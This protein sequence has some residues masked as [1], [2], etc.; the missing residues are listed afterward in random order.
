M[1]IDATITTENKFYRN[2][3]EQLLLDSYDLE[4]FPQLTGNNPHEIGLAQYNRHVWFVNQL[5]AL[6]TVAVNLISNKTY[7]T[8]LLEFVFLDRYPNRGYYSE[9][10]LKLAPKSKYTLEHVGQPSKLATNEKLALWLLVRKWAEGT[11]FLYS[12]TKANEWMQN[13]PEV[14][15]HTTTPNTVPLSQP[16]YKNPNIDP[17]GLVAL[18]FTCISDGWETRYEAE[19]AFTKLLTQ[20]TVGTLGWDFT[21]LYDTN[22]RDA[23]T[24]LQIIEALNELNK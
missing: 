9:D 8:Q 5:A 23:Y 13:R 3:E 22:F 15:T 17:N 21:K 6:Q 10:L 14:L 12:R 20:P 2:K 19:G 4:P 18:F 11:T 24:E 1:S 16:Q 7:A